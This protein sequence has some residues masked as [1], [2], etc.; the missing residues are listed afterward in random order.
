MEVLVWHYLIVY[1][2]D[3]G[4][5]VFLRR[6]SDSREAIR[7]RFIYERHAT[8]REEVVVL[9]ADSLEAVRN[10]HGRYF[11]SLRELITRVR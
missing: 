8:P 1:D 4:E 11:Y 7:E 2:R 6:F 3:D 9:S 5:I 10:T